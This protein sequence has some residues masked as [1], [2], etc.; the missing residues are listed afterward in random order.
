MKRYCAYC[1]TKLSEDKESIVDM[2][3]NLWKSLNAGKSPD[4]LI[5]EAIYTFIN[6]PKYFPRFNTPIE[7]KRLV[8][9]AVISP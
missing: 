6:I 1:G 5:E 2:A 3:I 9:G 7:N 4:N 8:R